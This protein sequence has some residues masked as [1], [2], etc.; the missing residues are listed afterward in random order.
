MCKWCDKYKDS[1]N[2]NGIIQTPGKFEGEPL[3]TVH[4]Y[5]SFLDYTNYEYINKNWLT[6][7]IEKEDIEL[8][9]ELENFYCVA[10]YLSDDGFVSGYPWT[11]EQNT[12]VMTE[13]GI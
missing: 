8:F 5:N 2:K 11:K 3:Y 6:V 10:I 9:P 4:F 12:D 1:L 13:E 7:K